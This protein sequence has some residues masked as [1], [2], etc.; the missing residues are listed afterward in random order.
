MLE[1]KLLATAYAETHTV[2]M[3][4][5]LIVNARFLALDKALKNVVLDGETLF[6]VLVTWVGNF[7]FWVLEDVIEF[8]QYYPFADAFVVPVF[9]SKVKLLS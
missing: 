8:L 7:L 3:E 9:K 5:Y 2:N 6:T 1:F 4:K